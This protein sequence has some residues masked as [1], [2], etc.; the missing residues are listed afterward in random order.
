MLLSDDE[1]L[2]EFMKL[3]PE[4]ILIRWVN[5]HLSRSTCGRRVSNLTSDIKDSVAYIHLLH[6]I[7]PKEFG[8]TT[9]PESVCDVLITAQF[10]QLAHLTKSNLEGII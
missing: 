1:S 3:S 10:Q 7:A 4:Q 9:E 8:V 5:Y 2:E 6:Q